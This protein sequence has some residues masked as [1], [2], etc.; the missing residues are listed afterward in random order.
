M[1]LK[2]TN[3]IKSIYYNLIYGVMWFY[4]CCYKPFLTMTFFWSLSI[5]QKYMVRRKI[6]E[7]NFT[8]IEC[9]LYAFHHLAHKVIIMLWPYWVYILTT[10][11]FA[12]DMLKFCRL[13]MP[14]IVFVATRLLLDNHQT[15]LGK[16]FQNNIK[17]LRRGTWR[18]EKCAQNCNCSL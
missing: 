18:T 15:G 1:T 11:T 8:F 3:K 12:T 17:I 4:V 14:Q 7:I 9:L 6:E 2:W 13:P 10:K 5:S 16:T